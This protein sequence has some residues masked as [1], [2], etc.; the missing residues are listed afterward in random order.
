MENDLIAVICTCKGKVSEKYNWSEILWIQQYVRAGKLDFRKFASE[1]ISENFLMKHGLT[2]DSMDLLV[3]LRGCRYTESII[4]SA[5]M[6]CKGGAIKMITI[7]AAEE[8]N[9]MN[10]CDMSYIQHSKVKLNH[11]YFRF[12]I[13]EEELRNSLQNKLDVFF[14]FF[15]T[16]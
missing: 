5:L 7:S 1:R 13:P 11:V 3:Q 4:K 2:Q 12:P 15:A 16:L 10:S 14:C 6:I 8:F 9:A